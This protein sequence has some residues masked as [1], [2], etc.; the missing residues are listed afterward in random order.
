M[1]LSEIQQQFPGFNAN[2]MKNFKVPAFLLFSQVIKIEGILS[3]IK[4]LFDYFLLI[5]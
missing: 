3:D 5:S 2:F 1:A 4:E